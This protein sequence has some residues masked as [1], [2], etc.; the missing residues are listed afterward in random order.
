MSITIK[1]SFQNGLL[2]PDE[3]LALNENEKVTIVVTRAGSRIRDA[4]SRLQIEA[5]PK[6]IRAVAEDPQLRSGADE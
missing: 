1:A 3:P 2:Q 5:D 4:A 6:L